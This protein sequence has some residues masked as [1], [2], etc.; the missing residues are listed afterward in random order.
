MGGVF[1]VLGIGI[2]FAFI[3]SVLEFL[4]NIRKV[5]VIEKV[6]SKYFDFIQSNSKDDR[7]IPDFWKSFSQ[8]TLQ[9]SFYIDFR[10]LYRELFGKNFVSF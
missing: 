7:P 4:W 5:A 6:S 2:F 10:F 3:L 8:V 9:E 1:V